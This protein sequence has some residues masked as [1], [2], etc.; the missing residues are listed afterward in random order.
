MSFQSSIFVRMCSAHDGR[1]VTVGEFE[2]LHGDEKEIAAIPE[3]PDGHHSTI[4]ALKR[5]VAAANTGAAVLP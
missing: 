5:A 4:Q 3:A 1:C 2:S